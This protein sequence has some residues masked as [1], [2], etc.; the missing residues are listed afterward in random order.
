MRMQVRS[1]TS[2]SGLRIW[3]CPELWCRL[4]TQLRSGV[5]VAVAQA[6]SYSSNSTLS[7]GTSM[8]CRYGPKKTKKKK[9]INHL[10]VN[11]TKEVKDLCSE[12]QKI[13]IK[14]IE[15]DTSKWKNLLCSQ[16]G[17]INAVKMSMIPKAV[18]R[19][20]AILIKIL[21]AL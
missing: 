4:Q 19:F 15:E 17:R 16:I 1:L 11:L 6:S 9:R 20:T 14:E 3:C 7:L 18:Y 13:L 2:H 8:C 12:N 5:T 21:K 10:G